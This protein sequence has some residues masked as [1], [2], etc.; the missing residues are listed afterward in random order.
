[1]ITIDKEFESLIPPLTAD[2]YTQLEENCI[3]EGIRDALIVWQTPNGSQVLVD[4]HNRYRIAEEHNL[5]Y[6]TE[7][8]EFKDRNEA[9]L[10]IIDNQ[11][12]RR[13]LI[14]YDRVLLVDKKRDVLA[15]VANEKMLSGKADPDKKSCQGLSQTEKNKIDR[16]NKT[17]YKIAD[18]AGTSEDTV[19][20][21]RNIN[22]YGSPEIVEK[23]RNKEMSINQANKEA[24]KVKAIEN[25]DND[26]VKA[27]VREGNLTIDQGFKVVKGIT[28]KSPTQTKKEFIS[29]IKSE[30]KEFEEKKADGVVGFDEIKKDVQNRTILAN[31]FYAKCLRSFKSVGE[32][33]IDVYS[34]EV[35]LSELKKSFTDDQKITLNDAGQE[36]IT[37]ILKLLEVIR[38]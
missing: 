32:A 23:V 13:N 1:M 19:R 33:F 8:K 25:S 35:D 34:G 37:R 3:A 7:A 12:G 4:G 9:K 31:N 2:E 6:R 5:P 17:D 16:Q 24:I 14:T 28:N 22:Q 30:R 18:A 15:E 29:D 38:T 27:Q 11:L 26:F 36:A 20:K 10:W 21:V